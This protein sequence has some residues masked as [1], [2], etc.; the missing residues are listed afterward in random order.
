MGVGGVWVFVPP[1]ACSF[2]VPCHTHLLLVPHPLYTPNTHSLA[3]KRQLP[4][5]SPAATWPTSTAL[6]NSPSGK[7]LHLTPFVCA[8]TRPCLKFA[9]AWRTTKQRAKTLQTLTLEGPTTFACSTTHAVRGGDYVICSPFFPFVF[10][11]AHLLPTS[12][13]AASTTLM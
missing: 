6:W 9:T 4:F 11:I 13:Q 12:P 3:W 1:C 5:L 7:D 2:N 10:Q 8:S